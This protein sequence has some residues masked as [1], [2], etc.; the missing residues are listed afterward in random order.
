[1]RKDRFPFMFLILLA[2]AAGVLSL[3]GGLRAAGKETQ[4]VFDAVLVLDEIMAIP[5]QAIPPALLE[6]AYAVAVI[7]GTI[8]VGFV[9]GGRHGKGVLS[10]RGKGGAWSNP[11]FISFTGGSVGWQIGAQAADLVL[12]FKS[13]RSVDDIVRGKFTLGADASVAAGPV[14]RQ[15]EA[16][17]DLELK[18]EIY[19]YSRTRGLFAGLS[20]EGAAL[21][22]DW[23][24]NEEF[25][26]VE[27]VTPG[28][29][30][31]GRVAAPEAAGRLREALSSYS[32]P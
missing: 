19:S 9:L 14:G 4:K 13:S 15:A 27:G 31:E 24:A 8:K 28:D 22:I 20:L 16:A 12:V 3:P 6:D 7:P 1:M 25:Y 29:V 21:Q 2:A 5:E 32:G 17:T 10:V 30:F 23:D 26:G 11:S 18:A